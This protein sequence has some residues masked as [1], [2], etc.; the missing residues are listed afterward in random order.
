MIKKILYI[1]RT[2]EINAIITGGSITSYLSAGCYE[3][4]CALV[5]S[6][7]GQSAAKV[8]VGTEICPQDEEI[9]S[10][11]L[12]VWKGF[13]FAICL[14]KGILVVAWQEGG[15]RS[16]SSLKKEFNK[17]TKIVS[18]IDIYTLHCVKQTASGKLL[19]NTGSQ[20]N[21]LW[22]PRGSLWDLEHS[23]GWGLGGRETKEGGNICM[24]AC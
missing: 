21:I 9:P 18:T 15:P 5:C 16:L 6:W 22:L 1:Q 19:Y 12:H 20:P 11:N 24:H 10:C 23:V 8:Q 14:L 4:S 3:Q 2:M 13:I 7:T 17:E